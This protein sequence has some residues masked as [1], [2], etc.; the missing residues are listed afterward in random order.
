MNRDLLQKESLVF[1]YGMILG[2]IGNMKVVPIPIMI[3]MVN[4]AQQQL[5]MM[6]ILLKTQNTMDFVMIIA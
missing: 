4:G 1:M 5:M 6:A 2:L 3:K